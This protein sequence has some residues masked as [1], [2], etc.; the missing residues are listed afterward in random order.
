MRDFS[1]IYGCLVGGAAGDALGYAVE[2]I[3]EPSI[4]TKYGEKGIQEHE[5]VGG[6]A[7]I[8][9]D[10]QMTLFTAEGLLLAENPMDYEQFIN[11][12][13]DAYQEWLGTQR[14]Q[15]EKSEK[16]IWLSSIPELKKRRAPGITCLDALESKKFGSI[17]EPINNSKGCGGVMR[18]APIGLFF[19]P[20]EMEWDE[21]DTRGAQAA[22]LTH[23]H[24]L[25]YISAAGLVHIINL[26]M[27]RPKM[28]LFQM[29]EDMIEKV[30]GLFA[31]DNPKECKIFEE[32][33]RKAADLAA[34]DV[35]DDLDAIHQLGAGWI[36]EEALAIAVYC[37]LKYEKDFDGAMIASVNHSG[38]SDSTGAITGNILGTYLGIDG[39]PAKYIKNLELLDVMEKVARELAR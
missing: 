30:P 11:G 9:D 13:F 3:R 25:G 15:R 8:S 21:I 28:T 17:Y 5:L 35:A 1:K 18:V 34:A 22:A 37:A 6:K 36:G 33:M 23:G 14:F 2:F 27:F 4:F 31:D 10:T 7:I 20:D 26:A 16:R 38:D 39:I 29:V 12:M 24:P 32:L 19:S